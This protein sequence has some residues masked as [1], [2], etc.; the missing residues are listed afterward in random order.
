[1]EFC[2]FAANLYPHIFAH[3]GRFVLIFSKMALIFLGVLVVFAV[4][5]FEFYQV[6]LPTRQAFRLFQCGSQEA[7]FVKYDK[8]TCIQK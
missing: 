4:S 7:G 2:Q 3:F 8:Y 5:S 1:V 6:K